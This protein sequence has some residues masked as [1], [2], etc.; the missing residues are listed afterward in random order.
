VPVEELAK[1]ATEATIAQTA[2]FRIPAMSAM[3]GDVL[4]TGANNIIAPVPV[5]PRLRVRALGP[6]QVLVDEKPIDPS[7]WGSARPRELLVYLLMHP[8]GRTKEHVGLAFWPESSAAQLRN[9]FHV[10]IHRLRKALGGSEWISLVNDRYRVD[11]SLVAEF[12]AAIFDREIVAARKALKKDAEGATAALERAL[13]LFRGDFLD[14]EPAGDWH[15]EHRDRFQR[16]Y[17]DGLMELGA[18]H[19]AEGRASRAAEAYR[20]VLARDELHEGAVTALMRAHA[21]VG[22]R[23]QAMRIYQRFAEKL[24]KELEVEPD[25]DTLELVAELKG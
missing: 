14:G 5:G 15:L 21:R 16:Q 13:D 8:E 24:R 25:E 11:Q 18:R 6:L 22:E 17:I 23:A 19:D 10:T 4:I 3:K 2:E 1:E 12:D 7:S 20:R 9:N